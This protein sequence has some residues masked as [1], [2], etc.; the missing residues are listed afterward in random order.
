M[1]RASGAARASTPVSGSHHRQRDDE[2]PW[3][4]DVATAGHDDGTRQHHPEQGVDPEDRAP[5]GDDEHEGTEHRAEHRAQLLHRADDAERHAAPVGGPELRDD[6]QRRRHQAASPDAL[7]DP[8]GHEHRQLGG[9]RGDHGTD[10]EDPE[11]GQQ[12][13]LPVDEVGDP[14]D[15]RQHRDVAQEEA[16]DDRRRPLQGVDADADPAHHVGEGEHDDVGVGGGEGDGDR[17]R[18]EQRPRGG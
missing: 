13:P 1:V 12:H 14:A 10:H 16:R 15:E 2:R 5:V 7:H 4:G 6:R 9:Q 8:A 18:R 3:A 11:A 17:G